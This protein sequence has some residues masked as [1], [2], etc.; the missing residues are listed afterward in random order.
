MYTNNTQILHLISLLKEYGISKVVISPGSRHYPLT[1]SL[2]ADKSF[3]LYSVVDERSA[4]F[5]ALGLIQESDSPVAICCSSGTA[6][7]NY[8][9]AVCEAYYQKLPLLVITIDRLSALLGQTEDQMIKQTNIYENFVNFECTLSMGDNAMDIWHSNRLINEALIKLTK[10]DNGPTH[11]NIPIKQHRDLKFETKTLPKVRRIFHHDPELSEQDWKDSAAMLENKRI[12]I[13]WG[14]SEPLS[15][16]LSAALD[17][18]SKTQ[19][20]VILTDSI[21]N[22]THHRAILNT[23]TTLRALSIPDQDNLAP[24]FVFTIGA[25][26]VFNLEIKGFLGA[27]KNKLENWQIN[28]GGEISDPFKRLTRVFEMSPTLFFEK[29][30]KYSSTP[31][32]SDSYF[33][34]WDVIA[35]AVP[36]PEVQYSQLQVLGKLVKKLP[37]NSV[38]QIANSN[39]IRLM[40]LFKI[41]KTV[42]C[43]CNRGVNGIDGCM[44]TAVGF[45]ASSD[46][47]VYYVTGDLTFFYDMNA[48][49]NRYIS[50]K[51][52]IVLINNEGGAVMHMPFPKSQARELEQY[53]S[54]YHNTSAKGWAESVGITYT[55]V[56]NEDEAEKAIAEITDETM[57]TPMLI[58]VFTKKEEDVEIVKSYYNSINKVK[59]IDRAKRKAY[60]IAKQ[61]LN[62]F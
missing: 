39:A 21:S 49:W 45:A 58:E 30:T 38:L 28:N 42:R 7:V 33:K 34:Q 60:R 15:N 44:S 53:T 55:S 24:D 50:K 8:S 61:Y 14:Q 35:Q 27:Y 23:F 18:F 31:G 19:N 17:E 25:N 11:I 32:E 41:K 52:R 48:L 29:I 59:T 36:E 20:Y 6:S 3:Q 9:S 13:V 40:H 1:H 22:C 37:E 10:K 57:E 2:E 51:L 56:T 4:A 54:A 43:Y 26:F 5:F 12:M 16:K 46:K 47:I 62:N